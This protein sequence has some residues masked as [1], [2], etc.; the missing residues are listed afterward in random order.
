MFQF[1]QLGLF[2]V[3]LSFG[4]LWSQE[5]PKKLLVYTKNGKG[6]VH[7]NIATSVA[8]IE[9][10]CQELG[11]ETLVSNDPSIFDS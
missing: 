4:F 2:I 1:K 7:D 9:K 5:Y 3:I 10:I 11:V 8:T 6:Y